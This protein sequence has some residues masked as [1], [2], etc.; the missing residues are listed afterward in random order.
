MA[1][2][3]TSVKAPFKADPKGSALKRDPIQVAVVEVRKDHYDEVPQDWPRK[4]LEPIK[5]VVLRPLAERQRILIRPVSVEILAPASTMRELR[6]R[7][8]A[9]FAVVIT[10]TG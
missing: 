8:G 2:K 3:K 10:S 5:E 4:L 9:K 1:A 6:K 7:L